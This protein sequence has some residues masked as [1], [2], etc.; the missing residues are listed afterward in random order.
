MSAVCNKE[1]EN[2]E[3]KKGR[4]L[5]S[6]SVFIHQAAT[7][8]CA[9]RQRT[10]R[11]A[12]QKLRRPIAKGQRPSSKTQTPARKQNQ[13]FSSLLEGKKGWRVSSRG[14]KGHRGEILYDVW[15]RGD[16]ALF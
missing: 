4:P 13:S 12:A 5:K 9:L 10:P 2:G 11:R 15:K 6:C 1:I 8:C 7:A 14:W 16:L 3:G